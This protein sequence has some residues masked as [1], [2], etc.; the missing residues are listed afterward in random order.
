MDR[1]RDAVVLVVLGA[2]VVVTAL[3]IGVLVAVSIA[4][5]T[6]IGII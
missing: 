6:M 4:G 3:W 5:L 1:E 2:I